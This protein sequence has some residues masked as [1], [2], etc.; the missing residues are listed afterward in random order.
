M[1]GW[2]KLLVAQDSMENIFTCKLI[3]IKLSTKLQS[4]ITSHGR[5]YITIVFRNELHDITDIIQLKSIV[6]R[7]TVATEAVMDNKHL[8]LQSRSSYTDT[9]H[10]YKMSIGKVE[11]VKHK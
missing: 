5:G 6:Q 2:E 3:D 8:D 9:I 1:K 4:I 10:D 11:K 7:S